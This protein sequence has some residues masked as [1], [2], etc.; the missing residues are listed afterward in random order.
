[1]HMLPSTAKRS[2]RR[3]VRQR[4]YR[5]DFRLRQK[6]YSCSFFASYWTTSANLRRSGMLLFAPV[7]IAQ[8][9]D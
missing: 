1:M 9:A 7:F 3:G 8:D 6:R 4:S 2:V 5:I